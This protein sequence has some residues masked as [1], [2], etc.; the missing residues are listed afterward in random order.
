MEF[1]S[2]GTLKETESKAVNLLTN[3]L[4]NLYEPH[5][6]KLNKDLNELM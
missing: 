2:T 3:G 4:L 1:D 6:S 5:F